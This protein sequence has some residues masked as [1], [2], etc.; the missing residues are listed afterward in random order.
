VAISQLLALRSKIASVLTLDMPTQHTA[1]KAFHLSGRDTLGITSQFCR[2]S[3]THQVR[4][5]HLS[6]TRIHGYLSVNAELEIPRAKVEALLTELT[7]WVGGHGLHLAVTDLPDS[8]ETKE[9]CGL[10]VTVLG[11]ERTGSALPDIIDTLHAQGFLTTKT[12]TIGD[13]AMVGV[14]LTA[15]KDRIS[16][17]E[18]STIRKA[19]LS[20][21]AQLRVDI[22][23]QRDDVY[24]TSKRLLCMDVD[25]TFVKGEF[26]D[27]LAEMCGVKEQVAAITAQAMRGELDFEQ[28]LRQR[29]QLLKGLPVS[30][31]LS[32]CDR[33]ELSPGADDLV[34]TAKHLGMRVGLVS[35]GFTLFVERLK[36][37]F[38]LDFAF[39]NELEVEQGVLTGNVLGTVVDSE[40]K[41]QILRDMAQ[42]YD[43]HLEQTIAAGDG[44][45]DML[46]LQTA[47]LGIAYQA[48]PRLVEVAGTYFNQTDRLDTLFYLMGFD[49]KK[50]VRTCS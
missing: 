27:E 50:L 18:L 11:D 1:R 22:A 37:Q 39:A 46:M 3:A 25:S 38:G 35:G 21:C 36:R 47:G 29:V 45:N 32:L 48:K 7:T 42:V 26:I 40:R 8:Y 16:K 30:K 9:Q 31:V 6:Q 24:R 10:Y 15:T 5:L 49:T 14:H 13:H 19:L 20:Q 28:A 2:M 17:A 43:V 33:F 4:F 44:A 41:A 34:R 23:V 12:E